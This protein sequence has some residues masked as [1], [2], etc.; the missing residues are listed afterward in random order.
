MKSDDLEK[1]TED[2]CQ[3]M[4]DLPLSAT[5]S[6]DSE[7]ATVAAVT[8]TGEWN[9]TL[10]VA[11]CKEAS[12]TI[13]SVMFATPANEVTDEE[14]AD[15]IAEVANMIGG[16]LKG[17]M[18]GECNLSIPCV[19]NSL[20]DSPT[21]A[22]SLAYKLGDGFVQVVFRENESAKTLVKNY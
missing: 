8:I 17:Q 12:A 14:I 22:I 3:A 7:P 16:N 13:A 15:A 2:V 18:G 9:A 10:E 5:D 21:E 20:W 1:V 4:L 6:V 19:G 11:T